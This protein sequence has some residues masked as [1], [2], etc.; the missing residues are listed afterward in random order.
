MEYQDI[1]DFWFGKPEEAKYGKS[2]KFWFIKDDEFDLKIKSQFQNI[3]QQAA[4]GKLDFWQDQP[5][6]CLA[7]IIILDQ[8][9]RNMF[10]GLSQAFATDNKAKTHAQIAVKRKFDLQLIPVQRWFIYLPFEHSENLADQEIAIRLFDSLQNHA[11]SKSAIAYAY[12]HREVIQKF[13]RFPHRNQ[14]LGR[15]NTPEET[16]FLQQPGSGF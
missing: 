8:F 9:P 1:L 16:K 7:L 3:Y 4:T 15:T 13:G 11:D 2:R 12:R 6:S 14:I 10:R 5:L